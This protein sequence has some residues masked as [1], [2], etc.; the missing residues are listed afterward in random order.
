MGDKVEQT[1]EAK[2]ES[3]I[4]QAG[5][6]INN[7][8]GP[9]MHE[10]IETIDY[11]VSRQFEGLLQK[12]APVLIQNELQKVEASVNNFKENMSSR[13]SE[14]FEILKNSLSE[15]LAGEKLIKGVT[16]SNFQY[17]FQDSLEQVIRKKDQAPQEV[18]ISLLIDKI[19]SED[20]SNYLIEEAIEVLK[21]LNKN[22]VNFIVLIDLIIYE[23]SYRL[24]M[25]PN[26]EFLNIYKTTTLFELK[27]IFNYFLKLNPLPIDFD[28]LTY[29]GLILEGKRYSQ[30]SYISES[31]VNLCIPDH[32]KN[33]LNTSNDELLNIFLPELKTLLES[34]GLLSPYEFKV[35]SKISHVIGDKCRASIIRSIQRYKKL[36]DEEKANWSNSLNSEL[37]KRG[38]TS[39][40]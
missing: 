11:Q 25:D 8:Y 32:I 40:H 37:L 9:K 4:N 19:T 17:L 27:W 10:I 3:T 28:Y 22:H 36:N 39:L 30:F 6:D 7:H 26:D 21:S 16:D 12:H 13:L 31:I 15:D 5:R 20:N 18:L 24:N 1:A 29:K 38:I 33:Q 35:L 34:F 2:D 23:L 14:Q